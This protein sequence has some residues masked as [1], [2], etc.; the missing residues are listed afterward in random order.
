LLNEAE[1]DIAAVAE[2]VAAEDDVDPVPSSPPLT[3]FQFH[4]R[5]TL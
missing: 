3:R 5:S 1:E 2:D 4:L